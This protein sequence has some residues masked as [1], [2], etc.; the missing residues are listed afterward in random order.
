MRSPLVWVRYDRGP[1]LHLFRHGSDFVPNL[2][3]VKVSEAGSSE[4]HNI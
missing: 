1:V 3:P 4:N 2:G